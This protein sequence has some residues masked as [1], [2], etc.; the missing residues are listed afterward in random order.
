MFRAA[1]LKNCTTERTKLLQQRK[2]CRSRMSHMITVSQTLTTS[3]SWSLSQTSATAVW[4]L[5]TIKSNYK[6]N[7][8]NIDITALSS[9][10]WTYRYQKSCIQPCH[11]HF[12]AMPTHTH[13]HT[14]TRLMAL[15]PGL[16]GWATTRK[17]KPIWILLKQE[18]V[19]GS[20]ISWAICKSAPCSRR[21]FDSVTTP[22]PYH[23]VFYRPDALPAAQPTASK[24]WRQ[25]MPKIC[26]YSSSFSSWHFLFPR[27]FS[28]TIEDTDIINTLLEPLRPARA[29]FGGF[30]DIASHFGGEIPPK[31]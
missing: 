31:P 16:P 12:T 17:V 11:S 5:M 2:R 25:P 21:M 23:S 10:E 1:I 14:H 28:G 18:T 26:R 9:I 27:D 15:F 30:V 13:T 29:P 8:P 19:S 20:G 7:W 6:Q 24:H 22:A 4:Y 3:V